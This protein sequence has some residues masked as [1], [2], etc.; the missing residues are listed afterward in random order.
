MNVFE[1]LIFLSLCLG[2][3]FLGHLIW[4]HY[5]WLL[6]AAA[7]PVLIWLITGGLRKVLNQSGKAK[8]QSS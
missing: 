1:L 3:G 4:P 5:G 2:L 7:I 6:G 8:D